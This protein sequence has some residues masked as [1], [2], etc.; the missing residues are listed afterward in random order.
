[1]P[2]MEGQLQT[3]VHGPIKKDTDPHPFNT[4][5]ARAKVTAIDALEIL[6]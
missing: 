5:E 4:R 6:Q 3:N 1:M 2:N